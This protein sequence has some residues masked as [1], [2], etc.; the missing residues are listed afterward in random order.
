[1]AKYYR[2]TIT[3]FRRN[4]TQRSFASI[5][6]LALYN[7]NGENIALSDGAT[8]SASSF[9]T[10]EPPDYAFD[11][12]G[13][14]FWQS[15]YI[16]ALND[17]NWLQICIPSDEDAVAFG[18][19]SRS[20]Y[21]DFPVSFT[22]AVSSDGATWRPIYQGKNLTTGWTKGIERR[23]TLSVE[24]LRYI[25]SDGSQYIDLDY[26]HT[27]E[28]KVELKCLVHQDDRQAWQALFGSRRNDHSS[29]AFVFFTRFGGEDIPVYNRSG[30]QTPGEGFLYERDVTVTCY[31]KT[32]TWETSGGDGGSVIAAGTPDGAVAPLALFSFLTSSSVSDVNYISSSTTAARMYDLKIYEGDTL[33]R[34]YLPALDANGVPHLFEQVEGRLYYSPQGNVLGYK[35]KG[36]AYLIR[37][38]STLYTVTDGAMAEIPETEVTAAVFQ[39][40]GVEELPEGSLLV[41]LTDPE[42]LYWQESTDELPNLSLTVKGTP[43]LPQMFTSEPM[44]LTHESIAGIDHA[45]VDASEDVRFA[46]S[47]DD[48]ANWKAFDGSAWFDVSDTAPGMLAS[49]MNAITAEQWAEVVQLTAYRLRF[50]LPNVTAFVKAV[51]IH[52]INP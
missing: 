40:Y 25:E 21:N 33:K 51:V 5:A 26:Y 42:V 18:I 37:S 13:G 6:E 44:D 36:G 43:P 29:N 49:T 12:S 19:T 15:D 14:T 2:I 31:Q 32:A 1:M 38:G 41:G 24:V 52:Y 17:T 10:T 48:G 23:F 34:H 22:L 35:Q 39:S 11:N 46:I 9:N 30:D 50:W 28:T 45:A 47:F 3:D 16:N 7:S 4:S 20:D 8:Y 27:S